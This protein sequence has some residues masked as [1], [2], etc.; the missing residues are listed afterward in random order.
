[1]THDSRKGQA[2]TDTDTRRYDVVRND[3]DQYSIWPT[4]RPLPTG[5]HAVGVSG[6]KADCLEHISRV[7]TDLRPR[8]LRAAM[9][10]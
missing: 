1:M 6:S 9:G 10:G 4:G 2:M 8:S 7:W 3:E 5:W